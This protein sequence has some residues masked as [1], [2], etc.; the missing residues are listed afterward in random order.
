METILETINCTALSLTSFQIKLKA[1]IT[2]GILTS[3]GWLFL[4]GEFHGQRS[5][6]GCSLWGLKESDTTE[7]LTLSLRFIVTQHYFQFFSMP[8]PSNLLQLVEVR[9]FSCNWLTTALCLK[10]LIIFRKRKFNLFS[11]NR[12]T[13]IFGLMSKSCFVLYVPHFLFLNS[14]SSLF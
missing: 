9:Y 10:I 3:S 6:V 14:I 12:I 7:W 4:T 8:F 1:G 2:S 11:F 5:L 13:D